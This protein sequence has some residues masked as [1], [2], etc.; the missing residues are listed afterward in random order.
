MDYED[1]HK[2]I[3]WPFGP[4]RIEGKKFGLLLLTK[5]IKN[6]SYPNMSLI[7]VGLPFSYYSMKKIRRIWSI[8]DI[9]KLL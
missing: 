6:Q 5:H 9:E 7:K 8:F 3:F 4:F 2:K 1:V